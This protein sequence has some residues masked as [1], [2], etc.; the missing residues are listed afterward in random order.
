M[1]DIPILE[2]IKWSSFTFSSASKQKICAEYRIVLLSKYS[3]L[4]GDFTRA[5]G[6]L[7]A[8]TTISFNALS[9]SFSVVGYWATTDK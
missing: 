4:I 3:M 5:S 1:P 9:V 8:E 2:V 6:V 7:D